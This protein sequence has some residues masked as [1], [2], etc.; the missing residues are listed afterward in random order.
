MEGD[1]GTFAIC[2]FWLAHCWALLGEIDE[3][4]S[5]FDRMAAS[6]ND[7]GLLAEEIDPITGAMLGNFPQA[8]THIGLVNAAWAIHQAE[9]AADMHRRRP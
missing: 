4:R 5:L 2:T 8:F 7:L 6:A 1:E 3:A 9:Q